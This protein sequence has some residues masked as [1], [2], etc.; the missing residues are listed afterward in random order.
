ME[1]IEERIS[2]LSRERYNCS[3]IMMQMAL[4]LRGLEN[5]ELVQCMRGLGGGLHIQHVCGTLTSGCCLLSSYDDAKRDTDTASVFLP[6]KEIV[7]SFVYWFEREFGSLLCRE[8][9]GGDM[10]KIPSFCP[11]LIRKSF[12]K[13]LEILYENGIDPEL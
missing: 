11:A 10:S 8:L 5:P 9:V 1:W 13:C 2:E 3:Q 4:E 12:E 7:K 6:G